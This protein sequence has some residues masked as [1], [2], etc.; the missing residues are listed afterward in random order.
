ME[1]SPKA[2]QLLD[3]EEAPVDSASGSSVPESRSV[4]SRDRVL[5]WGIT[6]LVIAIGIVHLHLWWVGYRA[7]PTIGPLFLVTVAS[8]GLIALITSVQ[9]NWVTAT[10]ATAFAASALVAYLLSLLLPHGLFN[11]EE[12]GVSYSGAISIV[13]ELGVIALVGTWAQRHVPSGDGQTR[14]RARVR[15]RTYRCCA[16]R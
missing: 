13:S 10:V 5:R 11:F 8:A 4:D 1:S 2:V 14:R 16:H 9:L 15:T 3:R 12:V 6:S 7:L